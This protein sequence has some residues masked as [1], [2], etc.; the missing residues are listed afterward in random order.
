MKRIR[1]SVKAIIISICLV[2]VL[3]GSII[4]V[5]LAT[6]N[7]GDNGDPI[8]PNNPLPTVPE[9][10]PVVYELT[11][12][13]KKMVEAINKSANT[14]VEIAPEYDYSKYVDELGNKINFDLISKDYGN[15]LLC[16]EEAG[17]TI[18]VKSKDA[19]DKVFYKD[20][21]D[22]IEVEGDITQTYITR[23]YI[24]SDRIYVPYVYKNTET[25]KF[26]FEYVL[27]DLSSEYEV[28]V[29][30]KFEN[31]FSDSL[32][33]NVT[34]T[35]LVKKYSLVLKQNYFIQ[36]QPSLDAANAYDY[37]FYD[38]SGDLIVDFEKITNFDGQ[39]TKENYFY[40]V[41]EDVLHFASFVDDEMKYYSVELNPDSLYQFTLTDDYMFIQK[42]DLATSEDK[43]ADGTN[44]HSYTLVYM[45]S[46]ESKQI[47]LEDG[48]VRAEFKSVEDTGYYYLF[49]HKASKSSGL[50]ANLFK[51]NGRMFY[52]DVQGNEVVNY[53][54]YSIL[55]KI[56]YSF[57]ERLLTGSGIFST[58]NSIDAVAIMDFMKSADF[59]DELVVNNNTFILKSGD[60]KS[61]YDL[62][63]KPVFEQ[64]FDNICSYND[65]YYVGYLDDECY[66][67]NANTKTP[68]KIENFVNDKHAY[69]YSVIMN[70][71]GYYVVDNLNDNLMS[72]HDYKGELIYPNVKSYELINKYRTHF[73]ITL[74][75]NT[76]KSF[77]LNTTITLDDEEEPIY[78][79]SLD[80]V[81]WSGNIK[82]N[83]N[84]STSPYAINGSEYDVGEEGDRGTLKATRA[85]FH[86]YT[87][88]EYPYT[89][90]VR[91]GGEEWTHIFADCYAYWKYDYISG[92]VSRR[93][94]DDYNSSD[95][96]ASINIV[97]CTT[98]PTNYEFRIVMDVKGTAG[99]G[100]VGSVQSLEGDSNIG[101]TGYLSCVVT[102]H[103]F[104]DGAEIDP[105]HK[106]SSY[107]T[108]K[109]V[110]NNVNMVLPLSAIEAEYP[111]SVIAE[112]AAEAGCT[113]AQLEALVVLSVAGS[114]DEN[115]MIE[116]P[117]FGLPD[118]NSLPAYKFE[119][120][121]TAYTLP[122]DV[123]CIG[124]TVV[125][126][127]AL[128]TTEMTSG[129]NVYDTND[130]G[131]YENSEI[132]AS[133]SD[134]QVTG[135][136]ELPASKLYAISKNASNKNVCKKLSYHTYAIY[137]HHQYKIQYE[138]HKGEGCLVNGN[139][140]SGNIADAYITEHLNYSIEVPDGQTVAQAMNA[141]YS[142]T[143]FYYSAEYT[144]VV[145]DLEG[146]QF[147]GWKISG[148][149]GCTHYY[150]NSATD[151]SPSS[152]AYNAHAAV[153]AVKFKKLRSDDYVDTDD[154]FV[155]IS[156]L[157]RPMDCEFRFYFGINDGTSVKVFVDTQFTSG[158]STT[159]ESLVSRINDSIPLSVKHNGTTVTT[160]ESGNIYYQG[161][162]FTYTPSAAIRNRLESEVDGSGN[163]LLIPPSSEV[164]TFVFNSIGIAYII[165]DWAYEFKT[166]SNTTVYK[167]VKDSGSQLDAY[168]ENQANWPANGEKA[169]VVL[170]AIYTR[171]EYDVTKGIDLNYGRGSLVESTGNTVP[172]PYDVGSINTQ[173][174]DNSGTDI[175]YEWKTFTSDTIDA[176]S[177][178]FATLSGNSI[179]SFVAN[180]L[181]ISLTINNKN[182]GYQGQDQT[183]YI[184]DRIVVYGFGYKDGSA[185]KF[186]NLIFDYNGSTW[187]IYAHLT[188][189]T[190][191][192]TSNLY[193]TRPAGTIDITAGEATYLGKNADD[194][195]FNYLA[196]K[197]DSEKINGFNIDTTSA[198]TIVLKFD[199]LGYAAKTVDGV[200]TI[201]DDTV[202][203]GGTTGF[204]VKAF[205]VSNYKANDV[206]T[207]TETSDAGEFE[208]VNVAGF[209]TMSAYKPD[210]TAVALN[211]FWLNG[212]RIVLRSVNSTSVNIT[213]SNHVKFEGLATGYYELDTSSQLTYSGGKLYYD[214][215]KT[216]EVVAYVANYIGDTRAEGL[217]STAS[218]TGTYVYF[219][220]N[221][222]VGSSYVYYLGGSENGSSYTHTSGTKSTVYNHTNYNSSQILVINPDQGKVQLSNSP[223]EAGGTSNIFELVTYLSK[224]KIGSV[225][226]TFNEITKDRTN[227]S[228]TA[229]YYDS[230]TNILTHNSYIS[231]YA[232]SGI[233]VGGYI[234]YFG[235][236]FEV[237][238][239]YMLTTGS[240][241]SCKNH[242]LYFTVRV[243]KSGEN[244]IDKDNYIRYFLYT[245]TMDLGGTS[246][247]ITFSDIP[248]QIMVEVSD[249]ETTVNDGRTSANV[250]FYENTFDN[251]NIFTEVTVAA[252][253]SDDNVFVDTPSPNVAKY[254][255]YI[256]PVDLRILKI[257][258]S[259]GFVIK[260]ISIS[261]T[262][263]AGVQS[264]TLMNF[265]LSQ[266]PQLTYTNGNYSYLYTRD[267][268]GA[269]SAG[270]LFKYQPATNYYFNAH[271]NVNTVSGTGVAFIDRPSVSWYNEDNH[272]NSTFNNFAEFETIFLMVSGIYDTISVKVVTAAYTEF[273][274]NNV[275]NALDVK[276]SLD[277]KATYAVNADET[278]YTYVSPN[279]RVNGLVFAEFNALTQSE[280]IIKSLSYT[281]VG[282]NDYTQNDNGAYIRESA[283]SDIYHKKYIK[284]GNDYI[285]FGEATSSE[286]ANSDGKIYIYIRAA[287]VTSGFEYMQNRDYYLSEITNLSL[288]VVVDGDYVK[289]GEG[290]AN[291]GF[292]ASFVRYEGS[293]I[294]IV[295]IGKSSYFVN[296]VEIYA[297]GKD[298]SAYFTSPLFYN[299][300]G[301]DAS[302]LQDDPDVRS[303]NYTPFRLLDNAEGRQNQD[304]VPLNI[305]KYNGGVS[306]E[307]QY[308][309][310]RDELGTP[311]LAGTGKKYLYEYICS[312]LNSSDLL[313]YMFISDLHN[314]FDSSVTGRFQGT[315][316]E[317]EYEY[318]RKHF[319]YFETHKNEV[320]MMVNSY[321]SNNNLKQ[322]EGND[323]FD[324]NSL[325]YSNNVTYKDG[326]GNVIA[327]YYRNL[328]TFAN[329]ASSLEAYQYGQDANKVSVYA[330]K[331]LNDN[332]TTWDWNKT[333]TNNILNTYSADANVSKT[334]SPYMWIVNTESTLYQL[335]YSNSQYHKKQSWFNDTILTNIEFNYTASTLNTG[336][337]NYNS[338]TRNWQDVE[339]SNIIDETKNGN[340]IISGYEVSYKYYTI[341]G[342][343]LD[344]IVLETVD[345]GLLY[346]KIDNNSPQ[347]SGNFAVSKDSSYHQKNIYYSVDKF[348]TAENGHY[349]ELK[350][351]SDLYVANDE[352]NHINSLGLLSNDI[353]V[354]FF[355]RAISGKVTYY[356]NV[357]TD[358]IS[359]NGDYATYRGENSYS[360]QN[361]TYDTM[362]SLDPIN[363][364]GSTL[365]SNGA[366][367]MNGYTFIGWGSK[368][369]GD[370]NRDSGTVRFDDDSIVWNSSSAWKKIT[371]DSNDDTT[372][373][374]FHYQNRSSLID[375][376]SYGY[377]FYVKSLDAI[378]A[379]DTGYFVTD[380]GHS[381]GGTEQNYNFWSAY[382]DI[383]KEYMSDD[384]RSDI[385]EIDLY[386]IWKANTYAVELNFNDYAESH[387]SSSAYLAHGRNSVTNLW[388]GTSSISISKVL[389][390]A[391]QSNIDKSDG[392][393]YCY[394]TFD[395][396]DWYIVSGY[397][398]KYA[399]SFLNS[400]KYSYRGENTSQ[401][402][403]DNGLSNNKLEFILDRYGYS[404]LGWFSEKL[405]KINEGDA[406]NDETKVFGSDYY[407]KLE[408]DRTGTITKYDRE[409][410]YLRDDSYV[411]TNFVKLTDFT[412][413][414]DNYNVSARSEFVY[415]GE[416][417]FANNHV[418][419][420]YHYDYKHSSLD[421]TRAYENDDYLN[422][423]DP[424][425][426]YGKAQKYFDGATDEF[427]AYYALA[428]YD[429]SL[430]LNAFTI[431]RQAN[432][433]VLIQRT[434]S[435]YRFITLYAHWLSNN[436]QVIIDYRD[437]ATYEEGNLDS[438]SIDRVG[439]SEVTNKDTISG[440]VNDVYFDDSHFHT[441]L[442]EQ[443]PTRVGYDF[444]GW[445]YFYVDP[446]VYDSSSASNISN[447]YDIWQG[448]LY[449]YNGL[450]LAESNY[451]LNYEAVKNNY[452]TLKGLGASLND[453]NDFVYDPDNN[454]LLNKSD[455]SVYGV[456]DVS[457]ETITIGS[458]TIALRI[459][460]SYF[461]YYDTAKG[462]YIYFS[463][464]SNIV[465][466][467]YKQINVNE[468][469][470]ALYRTSGEGATKTLTLI[471]E[472]SYDTLVNSLEVF[473]DDEVITNQTKYVYIFALWRAQTFSVNVSLNIDN[474]DLVN[475]YDQDSSYSIAFYD[476]YDES[477]KPSGYVGI[478][479]LFLK[480]KTTQ[481][482]VDENAYADVYTE[483]VS[484]LTFVITFDESFETAKF[485]D[486]NGDTTYYYLK[487]LFAVSAG[488]YLIGWLYDT[489]K[490]DSILIANTLQ[491][492]FGYNYNSATNIVENKNG[493]GSQ[494]IN[495]P[496][497]CD[498]TCDCKNGGG[499]YDDCSFDY[500]MY[501]KLHN[502][503]YKNVSGNTPFET[504]GSGVINNYQALGNSDA[505]GFVTEMFGENPVQLKANDSSGLSTNFGYVTVDSTNYYIQAD[506]SN[507][508]AGN[509]YKYDM[510]DTYYMYLI[511]KGVKYYVL[512]YTGSNKVLLNDATHLYYVDGTNRYVV[513]YDNN[514]TA[515]YVP[516]TAYTSTD[517]TKGKVNIQIK[518]ALFDNLSY[519]MSNN[520]IINTAINGINDY[521]SSN[522]VSNMVKTEDFVGT[523]T[524][525]KFVSL[526][527]RQF[528]VFAHWQKK[529]SEREDFKMTLTNGNNVNDNAQANGQVIDGSNNNPGLAG[530]FAVYN[531]KGES[532]TLLESTQDSYD[533]GGEYRLL[534]EDLTTYTVPFTFYDTMTLNMLPFF[535]GRYLTELTI[536]FDRIEDLGTQ[537][538][539]SGVF[540][541]YGKVYYRLM[542]DFT[543]NN[544]DRVIEISSITLTRR[545]EGTG[546]YGN[547]I[548]ANIY[549]DEI[550]GRDV[551]TFENSASSWEIAR[552]ISVLDA[553]SFGVTA[554]GSDDDEFFFIYPYDKY[555][556]QG[557]ESDYRRDVNMVSFVFDNLL[558]NV[559]VTYK[560]SIQTYQL[561]VHH[562][563]DENGDTLIQSSNPSIYTTQYTDMIA[564][565][566]YET[567]NSFFSDKAYTDTTPTGK[568]QAV[569]TIPIDVNLSMGTEYN[570][571]YGYFIYGTY[572]NSSLVGGRPMDAYYSNDAIASYAGTKKHRYDG[573]NYIY[574]DSYYVKGLGGREDLVLNG[575]LNDDYADQ[576]TPILGSSVIFPT[577]SIRYNKSF[578]TF[579]GW[580]ELG[581]KTGSGTYQFDLYD[582]GDE[583]TYI[584]ENITLF[585]YYYSDN[586]PTNLQFYTWN[587]DWSESS[588]AYLPYTNNS[589]EYTLSGVDAT[590]SYYVNE[591]G[592]LVPNPTSTID[593]CVDSESRVILQ[594]QIEYG[595]DSSGFSNDK[596]STYEIASS[597]ISKLDNILKTYWYY[598]E[599]YSILYAEN[600]VG[601]EKTY[602]KYDAPFETP[603]IYVASLKQLVNAEEYARY[604]NQQL[605]IAQV[606]VLA[607]D[608]DFTNH[609]VNYI[610]SETSLMY[611]DSLGMYYFLNHLD[612]TYYCFSAIN[613]TTVV[614][615]RI[616]EPNCYYY[617]NGTS[618]VKVRL[619]VSVDMTSAAI[620]I[621]NGAGYDA[622]TYPLAK[623][624]ITV[625]D[626]VGAELYHLVGTGSNA[627]YYKY[628]RVN[629]T[630]Y[631]AVLD[632]SFIN[633]YKPRYY[634]DIG[635]KRYYSMIQ[636]SDSLSSYNFD[637]LYYLDNVNDVEPS[638]QYNGGSV[639]TLNNYY[640]LL[641]DRYHEIVYEEKNDK[642]DGS[643]S[644]YVNP[645]VNPNRVTLSY[646]GVTKQVYF[647][648][649]NNSKSSGLYESLD[650]NGKFDVALYFPYSIYTP[651]NKNYTL[652][653]V[654]KGIYWESSDV[655]LSSFPSLNMD[656][657]YN[658]PEYILL[659]YLNVS[660]LDIQTMKSAAADGGGSVFSDS[661]YEYVPSLGQIVNSDQFDDYL[662]GSVSSYTTF[663]TV[664]VVDSQV[665]V[666]N[667]DLSLTFDSSVGLHCFIDDTDATSPIYYFALTESDIVVQNKV[668]GVDPD[669][670]GEAIDY[671]NTD[672][673]YIPEIDAVV[674]TQEYIN[675]KN[676]GGVAAYTT[677]CTI[678]LIAKTV[679][680]GGSTT[681]ITYA[682]GYYKFTVS[683]TDYYIERSV[684][685]VQVK[686]SQG[687]QVYDAYDSYINKKFADTTTAMIDYF[688]SNPGAGAT[689]AE[690]AAMNDFR[691]RL[692]NA[693]SKK[694]LSFSL[695]NLLKFPMFVDS[696]QYSTSD[697]KTI[698][699]VNMRISTE[700]VFNQTEIESYNLSEYVGV[701]GVKGLAV[702]VS[703]TEYK[704]AVSTSFVYSFNLIST[705]TQINQNIYAIPVY[706]PDVIKYTNDSIN[707]GV[708]GGGNTILNIDYSKMNVT[709]HDVDTQRV[710]KEDHAEEIIEVLN[711]DDATEAEINR[712]TP[713]FEEIDYLNFAM[714]N[715]TQYAELIDSEIGCDVKLDSII[716]LNGIQKVSRKPTVDGSGNYVLGDIS[717]NLSALER[718]STYY[719]FSFYHLIDTSLD[720][721]KHIQRVSDNIL[722]INIADDGTVTYYIIDNPKVG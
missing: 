222:S 152:N 280:E 381:F 698:E 642:N 452:Y 492:T 513:R 160:E 38:Y 141:A 22:Y 413:A 299:D 556:S 401:F 294:R 139:A 348:E 368:Y 7:K 511:Y 85:V 105:E 45:N 267:E 290:F 651:I 9:T 588:P 473:G 225:D 547:S 536:D 610:G 669:T 439:S 487:D 689:S 247:E 469:M 429:T 668:V 499:L 537:F 252:D 309:I 659:G 300:D 210:G 46:G 238:Q 190:T 594:T 89:G 569:A 459:N 358:N 387:G 675:H 48:Y 36:T 298:Y 289:L 33:E 394:I 112:A 512:L 465:R 224:L 638:N 31:L 498:A 19:Q 408:N 510:N 164:P 215:N 528:T 643:G 259:D 236:Y 351:Y 377:D 435:N 90:C 158:T 457:A 263:S 242:L 383:F 237:L 106:A 53:K 585:G 186:A 613:H 460:G 437:N 609:K 621:W 201:S 514:G 419:Y 656:Y 707:V 718:G 145:P 695:S 170:Y 128:T 230:F 600:L 370:D 515:Y 66:L 516:N 658:N 326:E 194:I 292:E 713:I 62:E 703:D 597:E 250:G 691:T 602:I 582:K 249:I 323:T 35:D 607:K 153:D 480:Q 204:Y 562:L 151:T 614:N 174:R 411:G 471:T 697:Y 297:T 143:T 49:K 39:E 218:A 318:A 400:D 422:M 647:N 462:M 354:N 98:N 27:F 552:Y 195:D 529:I 70:N 320:S 10:P 380:T 264:F 448:D 666:G 374:Y 313:T 92:T 539:T 478:N 428:Y 485:R 255:H 226:F 148:M 277:E 432:G 694:V 26:V 15:F 386:A 288:S 322:E 6:R 671:T 560:Y 662:E 96:V 635:G 685:N 623:E 663:A 378:K 178:T 720:S 232:G 97:E 571:P 454:K 327:N 187:R 134:S 622:A 369:Y 558:T 270:Y 272:V 266:I 519:I 119:D 117:L 60:K 468:N 699:R 216:E 127:T 687:G 640:V 8:T 449:K 332:T 340:P 531:G 227:T 285:F 21:Y 670:G 196:G 68:T 593:D 535:N 555:G 311:V 207:K 343:F 677:L 99:A 450:T 37:S 418:D 167:S 649:Q 458:K 653:P 629:E 155:T 13:Q 717:F 660:D 438:S 163:A 706:V 108:N 78:T 436:Y 650:A 541:R 149:D 644:I 30:K 245:N 441:E 384:T 356:A 118:L 293:L 455:N 25:N 567:K 565:T 533:V 301:N 490:A 690:L 683:G 518:V 197:N 150:Y 442:S 359:S 688:V 661:G 572:Y 444:I 284:V 355:S 276:G 628:H 404:W 564:E 209:S 80:I 372:N 570:V 409:M 361:F 410:P 244:F 185:Y 598:T 390:N 200:V 95:E 704:I 534:G 657:W 5:V 161:Y 686:A 573:Y 362:I 453:S 481:T 545:D 561:N 166:S 608:I 559:Y 179:D 32:E 133:V 208:V 342:Y 231:D 693:I 347:S 138:Y 625:Y 417:P 719:L 526:T 542:F 715:S 120:I 202:N 627:R 52:Y 214:Q 168:F 495:I 577:K 583:A 667:T 433:D 371:G 376:E 403:Y 375:L 360:T 199:N 29:V 175:A 115:G 42:T 630:L 617:M 76:V 180:D 121:D 181:Q 446:L 393:Y 415:K 434:G 142:A 584:S 398:V 636:K 626:F 291:G 271:K 228:G 491:T 549:T 251:T 474:E 523:N 483:V 296:G 132:T 618:A 680:S 334:F 540:A 712:A 169:K 328:N 333:L 391:I 532:K 329:N 503:N 456:V 679:T 525:G 2:V 275:N 261:I 325:V 576:G 124:G 54:A 58:E 88:G 18:L 538:G 367:S 229:N 396:N 431:S 619:E 678:D 219:D 1:N 451:T 424:T 507:G 20:I 135:N 676:S 273:V 466:Y 71:G 681:P 586:T 500:D 475:G 315:D 162:E 721:N 632:G 87:D 579:K 405:E 601:T 520:Q 631:D 335:D 664:S 692:L 710:Y 211:Y 220:K 282:T 589:S 75:D 191:L 269:S 91:T 154:P 470:V 213:D 136:V 101:S 165:S 312:G 131:I 700:F 126:Y 243:E 40:I 287:A 171:K 268:G 55:D 488:Y 308:E 34:L 461:Y 604:L 464:S 260:S 633:V 527:T 69:N 575:D 82:S 205:A 81:S 283:T 397:D 440:N 580:F 64:S 684:N 563:F 648:Y 73:V 426:T 605:T 16:E 509:S 494:Y 23:V 612:G 254:V 366:L 504:D 568:N 427:D 24:V 67:L 72:V 406:V 286:K 496:C 402:L 502:S 65:G 611:S 551:I 336:V 338:Q 345:F 581:V 217:K 357:D 109:V 182:S 682:D 331:R 188:G 530:F 310:Y 246:I 129:K 416:I 616:P 382:A 364:S 307:V 47:V 41:E 341:P 83:Q 258:P 344:Y 110:S 708:N 324:N 430:T 672:Y 407:Y 486:P 157:W 517:P 587:D 696:Y 304:Y 624:N 130:N 123:D 566:Q 257:S 28:K 184:F 363:I 501:L 44:V 521:T 493:G 641:N 319:L 253:H 305:D 423:V 125:G 599:K 425:A 303:G 476:D 645:I 637:G 114:F 674:N 389:A 111:D 339:K 392:V 79:T 306:L 420:V 203:G 140:A 56:Y 189:T 606:T 346:I 321:V 596:F 176:S 337:W 557:N 113:P 489:H 93:D 505:S 673:S 350:L 212:K 701:N 349:Y 183:Y 524:S 206:V 479:S 279:N 412:G 233:S 595:V 716:S 655:T 241:S 646:K 248:A 548:T 385:Y 395:K 388:S 198:T 240:G 50:L 274:I 177:P 281:K 3:A 665:R 104:D 711:R 591:H 553:L 302:G 295:F 84:S 107:G 508:A 484:N 578:Y 74:S 373:N 477:G 445:S 317:F 414:S 51:E 546:N 156:P 43:N 278:K 173:N 235:E 421:E 467:E 11:E 14:T 399:Q 221:E 506:Y 443:I 522:F 256:N 590:S 103:A 352:I 234:E 94:T 550:D 722:Q 122:S 159:S 265:A 102:A 554:T 543:W 172:N 262:D 77:E 654:T 59:D 482:T 652:N 365:E 63:G 4:G 639:T 705:K 116:H 17:R 702:K 447:T 615:K 100:H 709:H 379:K 314:F 147:A 144:P 137:E 472:G 192:D 86:L 61:I 239:A 57:N 592:V 193:E 634:V 353:T 497:D 330:D 620:R 223:T 603:Y 574:S 714:L 146:Y 12:D 316:V 463:Q 544:I